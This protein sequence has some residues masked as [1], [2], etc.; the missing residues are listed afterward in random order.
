MKNP[1]TVMLEQ[2]PGRRRD[3]ASV[4]VGSDEDPIRQMLFACQTLKQQ[5]SRMQLD[6]SS[7]VFQSLADASR[8]VDQ[9]RTQDAVALLGAILETPQLET[10]VLLW[11]WA[12]LRE[13]GIRPEESNAF[14]VLGAI[15]EV[16]SGGAYDT[17]AAYVDGTARYLNFSGRAIF[18]DADDA[19]IRGLC[20]AFI[21]STVT[22]SARAQPRESL[23]LP[24]AG[25]QVTM[26]TR[27]GVYAYTQPPEQVFRSG[28][29]LMSELIE[30]ARSQNTQR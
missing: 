20:Q 14:Q 21:D 4:R 8:L 3:A 26:L 29:A 28:A 13:L 19:D 22:G 16:P 18:W 23:C 7:G 1:F 6:G 25:S 2:L 30:R 9:G 12:A 27:A 24:T 10:R 11:V 5:V 17:L 15:I